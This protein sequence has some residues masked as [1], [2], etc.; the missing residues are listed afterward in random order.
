MRNFKD[1]ILEKLKISK[2]VD[3]VDFT[4]RDLCNSIIKFVNK[5]YPS[6]LVHKTN[7][8]YIINIDRIKHFEDNPLIITNETP[9]GSVFRLQGCKIGSMILNINTPD[10][11]T[12]HTTGRSIT[13]KDK[14]AVNESFNISE[15]IFCQIFNSD[16]LEKLYEI[17]NE[18]N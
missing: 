5:N 6:R 17:L 4:F 3:F 9:I 15:K 13:L 8:E 14:F 1:I 2:N 18:K 11:I 12:C 7:T 10:Y 16:D